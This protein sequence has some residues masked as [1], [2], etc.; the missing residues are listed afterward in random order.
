MKKH[1]RLT[2]VAG[3]VLVV[4]SAEFGGRVFNVFYLGPVLAIGFSKLRIKHST[5]MILYYLST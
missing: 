3:W 1:W 5:T 2:G 4:R